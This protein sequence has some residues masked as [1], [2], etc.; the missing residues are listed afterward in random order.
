MNNL[1]IVND[2][3]GHKEGDSSLRQIG[4]I[5]KELVN[6]RGIAGR[7]GGDEFTCLIETRKEDTGEELIQSLYEKFDHYNHS[8]DKPYLVT[9]SAGACPIAPEDD[10]SLK[11]ALIR[12]DQKLYEV[13]K[14]RK[15]EVIKHT[16]V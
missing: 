6:G 12:A 15:W 14:E 3:F 11:E 10:I 2:R 13:K 7:V 9:V 1:K 16:E 4:Q 8:S 5:L